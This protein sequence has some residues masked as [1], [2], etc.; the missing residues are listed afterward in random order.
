MY[1]TTTKNLLC[2]QSNFLANK[3]AIVTTSVMKWGWLKM[4]NVSLMIIDNK[5]TAALF[6]LPV[7]NLDY[8][9]Q[10][11]QFSKPFHTFIHSFSIRTR[12]I[13]MFS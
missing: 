12:S 7:G 9:L 4:L 6:W 8:F 2:E 3:A 1:R 13:Q 5:S 10:K 11:L